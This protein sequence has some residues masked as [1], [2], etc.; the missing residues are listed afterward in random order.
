MNKS[1]IPVKLGHFDVTTTASSVRPALFLWTSKTLRVQQ[2]PLL[3]AL[4]TFSLHAQYQHYPLKCSPLLIS[5]K[6]T[7][8]KIIDILFKNIKFFRVLLG[9]SW[10]SQ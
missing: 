9:K 6:H 5:D 8:I 2:D 4:H 7:K 1:D 3:F 10:D